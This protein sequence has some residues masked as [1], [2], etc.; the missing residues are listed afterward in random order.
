M[1]DLDAA[2]RFIAAF[3]L[4]IGLIALMAYAAK[5]WRGFG[6]RGPGG[7]GRRLQVVE[8]LGIDAKR[9]LV[10][11]RADGR[12]HLLMVGGETDLVISTEAAREAEHGEV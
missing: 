2:L 8:A 10:L 5:R 12:E 11:I 7:G 6:N 9:R 3:A 4:V 1:I